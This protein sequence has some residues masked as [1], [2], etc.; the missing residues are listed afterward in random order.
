[1]FLNLNGRQENSNGSTPVSWMVEI[2]RSH[3]VPSTCSSG[4]AH[5]ADDGSTSAWTWGEFPLVGT[6]TYL[7]DILE[8]DAPEKYYLSARAC[9]GILRR[10]NERGKELPEVLK[11]ALEM[12]IA[13]SEEA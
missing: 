8:D 11:T 5:N 12:R 1:M 10:A 4:D 3:G 7:S 6:E 2:G 9:A 13:D